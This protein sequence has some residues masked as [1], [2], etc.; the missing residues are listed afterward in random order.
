MNGQ[1]QD[2]MM[3]APAEVDNKQLKE[4]HLKLVPP[5]PKD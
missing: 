2:L 4:L 1:A 5:A 3:N